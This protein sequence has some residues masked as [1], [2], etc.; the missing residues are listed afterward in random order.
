[1]VTDDLGDH[2]LTFGSDCPARGVTLPPGLGGHP[3]LAKSLTRGPAPQAPP[4]Q[5]RALLPA[6]RGD[7]ARPHRP[8][9]P[10]SL[11]SAGERL[12]W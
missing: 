6:S 3:A 2:V 10:Y 5:P 11:A 7:S 8:G 4:G 9:E 12:A 1:M